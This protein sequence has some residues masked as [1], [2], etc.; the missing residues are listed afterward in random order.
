[1]PAFRAPPMASTVVQPAAAR[2]RDLVG[3]DAE[4]GADDRAGIRSFGSSAAG[5]DA[6]ALALAGVDLFQLFGCP[7]ARHRDRAG[8]DV[9]DPGQLIAVEGGDAMLAGVAVVIGEHFCSGYIEERAGED[10][11]VNVVVGKGQ[12]DPPAAPAFGHGPIG[13]GNRHRQSCA[14]RRSQRPWRKFL[15]AGRD[16]FQRR[17]AGDRVMSGAVSASSRPLAANWSVQCIGANTLPW[18]WRHVIS[19]R[20]STSP[21]GLDDAHDVGIADAVVLRIHRMDFD[22]GLGDVLG[23]T[24]AFAGP[25]HGVPVVA[26]PAG[27]ED[28][29]EVRAWCGFPRWH[30]WR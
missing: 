2:R 8:C 12:F 22:E 26:D 5:D 21:R 16:M 13:C 17:L 14:S 27:V 18:R 9:Q 20:T 1:M 11:P 24:R 6:E 30:G 4:T 3:P 29:R 15:D 23:Q 19:A 28:E 10:C 7:A 25:R